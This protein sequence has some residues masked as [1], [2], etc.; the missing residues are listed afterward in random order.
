MVIAFIKSK[1]IIKI[2][3]NYDSLLMKLINTISMQAS[4]FLE[5]QFKSL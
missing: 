2:M 5:S 1:K 3:Q 4:F